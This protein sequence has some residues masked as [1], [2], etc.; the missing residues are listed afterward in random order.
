MTERA[1][2]MADALR[3]LIPQLEIGSVIIGIE[4][5]D[6]WVLEGNFSNTVKARA[7]RYDDPRISYIICPDYMELVCQLRKE[8]IMESYK[9][10]AEVPEFARPTIAMLVDRGLLLGTDIDDLGLTDELVRTLVILDRA[11]AFVTTT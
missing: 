5:D 2:E 6:L 4:G 9:T 10:V 7:I 11:G 8:D 1:E 3:L